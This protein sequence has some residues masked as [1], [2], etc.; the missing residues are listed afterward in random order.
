MRKCIFCLSL[1]LM[2][3]SASAQ[4]KALSNYDVNG[5]GEV[6]ITDVTATAHKVLNASAKENTM[7]DGESLNA[8]LLRIEA[9]LKA[10]E[11]AL[12]IASPEPEEPEDPYNGHE[13]VDLG[14][15]SGIKWATVNVGA[16][17]PDDYG[18]Y[19]SWG[20]AENKAG[21]HYWTNYKW[22]SYDSL[23]KY[24]ND[25]RIGTVDNKSQLELEDDAARANWGGKWRMPTKE[26]LEELRDNCTWT[27]HQW[28]N[29]NGGAVNGFLFTSKTN[30]NT[31]FI[32]AAGAH[33]DSPNP[34]AMGYSA[35]YWSSTLD[36]TN[37][38]VA[39]SMDFTTSAV[40]IKFTNRYMGCTIRAVCP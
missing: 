7:V 25:D 36:T 3:L 9:R 22:G 32:P 6:T 37:P 14:L 12:G 10:I 11:E 21:N 35:N 18:K 28:P 20:E 29:P 40:T 16:L 26:E 15:P 39:H 2:C 4:V 30:G 23:S 1:L 5:D 27:W 8:L 19:Y 13:Y 17:R 33:G 31:I 24:C 38:I 34:R